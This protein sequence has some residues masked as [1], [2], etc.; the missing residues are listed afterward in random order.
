MYTGAGVGA[1]ANQPVCADAV[2]AAVDFN[3]YSLDP[4]IYDELLLPD[5][6]PRQH[7]RQLYDALRA[8]RLDKSAPAT[9]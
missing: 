2:P 4:A 7:G 1:I 8:S 3:D 5:G 6:T 9:S